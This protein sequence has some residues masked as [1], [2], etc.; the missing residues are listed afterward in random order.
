[1]CNC[2]CL[3]LAPAEPGSP[4]PEGSNGQRAEEAWG[5]GLSTGCIPAHISAP[6][7]FPCSPSETPGARLGPAEAA[8]GSWRRCGPWRQA[9]LCSAACARPDMLLSMPQV[10]MGTLS[11]PQPLQPPTM[12]MG[13]RAAPVAQEGSAGYLWGALCA[14][15]LPVRS[16]PV[17]VSN[18]LSAGAGFLRSS[19]VDERQ[20]CRAEDGCRVR[21]GLHLFTQ[22]R[23]G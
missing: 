22:H 6:S 17:P 12:L 18:E 2:I 3:S 4:Q 7:T 1:M 9:A 21:P 8:G 20:P 11:L 19:R 16:P 15:C 14:S 10:G 5:L 23:Q 13:P